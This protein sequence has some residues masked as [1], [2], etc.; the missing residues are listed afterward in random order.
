VDVAEPLDRRQAELGTAR[1]GDRDAS[2]EHLDEGRRGRSCR[3][4]GRGSR[5]GVP[6]AS[7]ASIAVNSMEST[8]TASVGSC[9]GAENPVKSCDLH[10]LV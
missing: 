9:V 5:L 1:V 3:R 6:D 2:C 10:V 8:S 7:A 4:R